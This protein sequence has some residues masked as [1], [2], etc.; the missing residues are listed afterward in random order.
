MRTFIQLV[1]AAL[2]L[3]ATSI[4]VA[5]KPSAIKDLILVN[6]RIE[7]TNKTI[8]E[9][10]I[11]A[12]PENVTTASGGTH[13]CNGLNHGANATP[14]ATCTTALDAAAKTFG[15]TFDGCVFFSFL[16]VVFS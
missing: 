14:G 12:R 5:A 15:F 3:P 16:A 1:L 11:L 8:Y 6:L 13:A 2:L 4:H 7:G 10:P 9:G